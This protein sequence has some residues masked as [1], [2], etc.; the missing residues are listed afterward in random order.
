[1]RKKGNFSRYTAEELAADMAND[2]AWEG[3][4]LIG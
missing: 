3:F 1:M 2:P 4:P